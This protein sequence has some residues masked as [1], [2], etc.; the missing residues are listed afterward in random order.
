MIYYIC[1][2][3]Q[4]IKQGGKNKQMKKYLVTYTEKRKIIKKW[5]NARNAQTA[6]NKVTKNKKYAE[7]FSVVEYI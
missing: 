6:F 1:S 5:T 3:N 2:T 7:W 4:A